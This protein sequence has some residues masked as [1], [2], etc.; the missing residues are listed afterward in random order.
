MANW[1]THMI[2]AEKLLDMGLDA[3]ARG[4]AVGNI[5]PDCNMENADWSDFTP[6]RAVTHWMT[7]AY[8]DSADCEAFWDSYIRGR[9]FVSQEERAFMLGYY[10]HLIADREQQVFLHSPEITAARFMRIKNVPEYAAR[11]AGM[12]ETHETIRKMFTRREKLGDL[13]A[14][15]REM[16]RKNPG[17]L[18]NTVLRRVTEFPDYIDYLPAGAIAR[19]IPI[20]LA[21]DA[22]SKES[23]GYVF[24]TP[25]EHAAYISRTSALI[26][27]KIAC[28][29]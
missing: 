1:I 25:E 24:I 22:A 2:I 11:V 3:D 14:I 17:S 19:K 5:A 27:E 15:E 12:P 8:K 4:F 13:V 9:E 23:G 29:E 7:G 20:M 6:P 16:L 10:A 21:A 28:H 18:Y 26:Y